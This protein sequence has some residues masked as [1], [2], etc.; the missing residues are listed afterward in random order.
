MS[1]AV[2]ER[3]IDEA[4]VGAYRRLL[5]YVE[6]HGHPNVPE[7]FRTDDEFA[8]GGWAAD[9]RI[10]RKRQTIDPGE[11]SRLNRLRF[12]WDEHVENWYQHLEALEAF[13]HETGHATVPRS[14]NQMV[15]SK[16][17]RLGQWVAT[18]R[19]KCQQDKL[20]EHHIRLLE[21]FPEWKWT[22]RGPFPQA[23]IRRV[24]PRQN[25]VQALK[26]FVLK[27]GHV[28]VPRGYSEVRNGTDLELGRWVSTQRRR[29]QNGLIERRDV[30]ELESFLGWVW[31][32]EK[33]DFRSHLLACKQFAARNGHLDVP[34]DHTERF[35]G[36]QLQLGRFLEGLER[37]A[38]EGQLTDP[39]TEALIDLRISSQLRM[40][41]KRPKVTFPDGSDAWPALSKWQAAQT[42]PGELWNE[43]A[44]ESTTQYE[45]PGLRSTRSDRRTGPDPDGLTDPR[46]TA[47]A[48]LS[49]NH[50]TI[51]R[52]ALAAIPGQAQTRQQVLKEGQQRLREERQQPLVRDLQAQTHALFSRPVRS[53]DRDSGFASSRQ[54]ADA[55]SENA[56]A[57]VRERER[58]ESE[59][60]CSPLG[61][62]DPKQL[63]PWKLEGRVGSGGQSVLYLGWND[64]E[65][66]GVKVPHMGEETDPEATARLEHEVD[67]LYQVREEPKFFP[68][69]IDGGLEEVRPWVALE[70]IPGGPLDAMLDST[71]F[72]QRLD[73]TALGVARAL[74]V[75]HGKDIVHGDITPSN[76]L[77][78]DDGPVVIDFGMAF[79]P[80]FPRPSTSGG[81]G[82]TPGYQAPEPELT[83]ASDVFGWAATLFFLVNGFPRGGRDVLPD[84]RVVSVAELHEQIQDG[85][86]TAG[87]IHVVCGKAVNIK[88]RESGTVRFEL[89]DANGTKPLQV[90]LFPAE[91][92]SI[93][94]KVAH[95]HPGFDLL[96][97]LESPTLWGGTLRVQGPLRPG[98]D[99]LLDMYELVA[100][101]SG[102]TAEPDK[103]PA[104]LAELIR[105]ALD[106]RPEERPTAGQIVDRLESN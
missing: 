20:S 95:S 104:K 58:V 69:V 90:V 18:Q 30:E 87:T 64:D 56:R 67:L 52:N 17:Y 81:A 3:P 94:R 6:E 15:G 33:A 70:F 53:D 27:E 73:E 86:S 47:R 84:M 65:C 63:G 29:F 66:A 50:S 96:D 38:A 41:D 11:E 48:D 85:S 25:Y 21:S 78:T 51:L 103:I 80:R 57:A 77:L 98:S 99:S 72:P 89:T 102:I 46:S 59:R 19:K 1:R 8:L 101:T 43:K 31:S 62:S 60:W 93:Q 39:E 14:H 105:S 34:G 71:D 44:S 75:L 7:N 22:P 76:I 49:G 83:T 61:D 16:T 91:R 82:G 106:P 68:K 23:R 12:V 10:R 97:E 35:V 9:Q 100:P 36:E 5:E 40:S 42:D 54:K 55:L 28:L 2:E 37:R 24:T 45:Q 13:V 4:W 26:R 88:T 32:S 74:Q 92:D 79:H